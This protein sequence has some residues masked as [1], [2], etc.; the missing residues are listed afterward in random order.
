M[1][2]AELLGIW[3]C[4]VVSNLVRKLNQTLL[5]LSLGAERVKKGCSEF[6]DFGIVQQ[7]LKPPT[8]SHENVGLVPIRT[9]AVQQDYDYQAVVLVRAADAVRIP[10]VAGELR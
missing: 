7:A 10:E 5:P 9:R 8:R 4:Q 1:L 2:V 6:R 3:S